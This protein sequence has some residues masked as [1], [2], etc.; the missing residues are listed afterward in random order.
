M[1]TDGLPSTCE[2]LVMERRVASVGRNEDSSSLLKGD[3]ATCL[4]SFLFESC[5]ADGSSFGA[6][7]LLTGESLSGI[8]RARV[9]ASPPVLP[10]PRKMTGV[11]RSLR[12]SSRSELSLLATLLLRLV[13]FLVL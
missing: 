4:R 10:L 2:S 3:C 12:K 9:S 11:S 6:E 1:G 8:V 7:P 5:I 13:D